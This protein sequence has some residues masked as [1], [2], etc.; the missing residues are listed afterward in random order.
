VWKILVNGIDPQDGVLDPIGVGT[1][2]FETYFNKPMDVKYKPQLS[3]GVR[4]PYGKN[5]QN[6]HLIPEQKDHPL[7]GA[8]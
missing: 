6:D 3:M 7:T 8:N 4:Y 5:G 2:K 1:H